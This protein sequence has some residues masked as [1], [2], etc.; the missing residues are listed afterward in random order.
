MSLHCYLFISQVT[1]QKVQVDVGED[2]VLVEG[3]MNLLDVCIPVSLDSKNA[4][5]YF[6]TSSKVSK[7]L[8]CLVYILN[9]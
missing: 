5:A 3:P 6:I 2:R 1:G 9:L 4:K 8:S 7:L